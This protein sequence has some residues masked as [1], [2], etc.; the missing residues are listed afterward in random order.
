MY[1]FAGPVTVHHLR[2]VFPP[3]QLSLTL[4]NTPPRG[5][6]AGSVFRRYFWERDYAR[7][8]S[9]VGVH[10]V[11]NQASGV[12]FAPRNNVVSSIHKGHDSAVTNWIDVDFCE[13]P[14]RGDSA[15][16][17]VHIVALE[18]SDEESKQILVV[19]SQFV[20]H[21][22]VASERQALKV[23]IHPAP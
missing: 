2:P 9:D 19:A 13:T 21:E 23:R 18:E 8:A 4:S 5:K 15:R 14:P 12:K 17:R 11:G 10:N 3:A 6:R 22:P 16:G 20:W 7:L 1:S